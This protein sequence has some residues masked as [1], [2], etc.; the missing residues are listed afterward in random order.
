M[1]TQPVSSRQAHINPTDPGD[2]RR[3]YVEHVEA[4]SSAGE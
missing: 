2:H 3:W 4:E 1:T